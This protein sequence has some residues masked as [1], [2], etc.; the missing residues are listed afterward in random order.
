[1]EGKL[2]HFFT[3]IGERAFEV[4]INDF[5]YGIGVAKVAID[6]TPGDL[7]NFIFGKRD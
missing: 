4:G 7:A 2:S 6:G 1:M 3:C 5:I